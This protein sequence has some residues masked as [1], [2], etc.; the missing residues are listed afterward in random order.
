[1]GERAALQKKLKQKLAAKKAGRTPGGGAANVA[2]S[3]RAE[4]TALQLA[5]EDPHLLNMACSLLRGGGRPLTNPFGAMPSRWADDLEGDKEGKG[6]GGQTGLQEEDDE[7]EGPPPSRV[8]QKG[9]R[10]EKVLDP[11]PDPKGD[12]LLAGEEE[13]LVQDR[14]G[15]DKPE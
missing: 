11:D 13:G 9:G 12:E 14:G 8:L 6:N 7:E 3:S 15:G 10:H 4:E 2:A 1:M 5:G